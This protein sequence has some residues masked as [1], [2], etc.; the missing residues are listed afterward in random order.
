MPRGIYQWHPKIHEQWAHEQLC[1]WKLGFLPTYDRLEIVTGIEEAL[2]QQGGTTFTIYELSAGPT[3][4]FVRAWLPGSN[5][6]FE[7]ALN[8]GSLARYSITVDGFIVDHIIAHWPWET[9]PNALD[10]RPLSHRAP[11]EPLPSAEIQR[12]NGH[13]LPKSE[14]AEYENLNL[15][16][17]LRR[18]R[19]VKFFT[20]IGRQEHPLT[21]RAKRTLE[22]RIK[23]VLRAATSIEEKSLY[24]GKGFGDYLLMG[25]ARDYFA[26][27][28]EI[29]KPLNDK[30]DPSNGG[31]RTW[32]YQTSRQEFLAADYQ[33]TASPD[34]ILPQ[35]ATDALV[36]GESQMVEV[37]G[38][39][40]VDLDRWLLGDGKLALDDTVTDEGFLKAATGLLNQDG[41]T[42]VIGALE[43]SRYADD[44]KA[45]GKLADRPV[46][47]GYTVVGIDLDLR[48]KDWDWYELRLKRLLKD[49][50]RPDP[51]AWI[52]ITREVIGGRTVAVLT[53]RAGQLIFYHWP[54]PNAAHLWTRQGNQTVELL[55]AELERFIVEKYVQ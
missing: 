21:G 49:R 40:L 27:E 14:R 37:K 13:A 8:E 22:E 44:D 5:H 45:A 11:R 25:R 29:T 15:I 19:G 2:R 47:G 4:I 9:E 42:L 26:I 54:K 48:K 12:I 10:I 53:I 34:R 7:E 24:A 50:V 32:T 23:S 17:P 38:S 31:A 52:T 51:N 20:V 55:G 3:D 41:G 16:A 43:S 46:H 30:V 35:S 6:N 33:L 18:R 1:F 36:H 39:V 28:H